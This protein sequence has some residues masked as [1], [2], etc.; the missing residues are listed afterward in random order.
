MTLEEAV[1]AA[2]RQHKRLSFAVDE[3]RAG[4][5]ILIVAQALRAIAAEMRV[6]R[7]SRSEE[8]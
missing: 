3:I 5:E 6:T 4:E 7:I 8:T 1:E 2:E